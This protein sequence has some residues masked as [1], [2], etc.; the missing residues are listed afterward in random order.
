MMYISNA[1]ALSMLPSG[2]NLNITPIELEEVKTL[3]QG[4]N[5]TSAVG[6][7]STAEILT[8]LVGIEIPTNRIS[9]FLKQGDILIVFQILFRLEEGKVL[10]TEEILSLLKEGK[11]KFY[12]VEVLSTL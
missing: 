4:G 5:F 12:K 3:L 1:F 6:H 2:G 9:I 11:V 8:S 10:Q 7:S